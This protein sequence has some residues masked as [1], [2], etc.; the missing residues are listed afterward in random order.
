[1]YT[2]VSI[3]IGVWDDTAPMTS[4]RRRVWG[5]RDREHNNRSGL[6]TCA[7]PWTWPAMFGKYGTFASR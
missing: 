5:P 4:I 6:L 7:W 2:P 3:F 1:V